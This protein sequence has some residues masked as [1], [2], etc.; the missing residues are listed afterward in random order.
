MT[1]IETPEIARMRARGVI[2]RNPRYW[3]G[4]IIGGRTF[5]YVALG[6]F[7]TVEAA[8]E[9]CT[10]YGALVLQSC[11]VYSRTSP[12]P[13]GLTSHDPVATSIVCA[14]PYTMNR[15]AR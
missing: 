9:R 10:E 14:R 7:P 11:D 4:T 5:V 1:P 13:Y 15:S 3:L 12:A 2:V 8:L 6:D